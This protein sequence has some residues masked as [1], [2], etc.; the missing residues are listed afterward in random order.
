MSQLT[1][2]VEQ[3]GAGDQSWLGSR[4]GTDVARSVSLDPA[5]WSGKVADGRIKSG[6]AYALVD[7]LAVPYNGSGEDGT[8]VL[9]GF[10]L[11]DT[12][13]DPARGNVSTAGLWTGRIILS[14]LPSPVAADA[15]ASGLF[16]L[17]A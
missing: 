14:N 11:S 5:A 1:P 16:V 4:T 7:G 10:V 17:E 13:V 12:A 15:T 2:S 9:A 3:V 8:E 6:E